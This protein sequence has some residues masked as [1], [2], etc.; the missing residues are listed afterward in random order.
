MFQDLRGWAQ[1]LA[2]TGPQLASVPLLVVEHAAEPQAI[3]GVPAQ[4]VLG[5]EQQCRTAENHAPLALFDEV[6]V[7]QECHIVE[8]WNLGV[9]GDTSSTDELPIQILN[10]L[11]PGQKIA[12][13]IGP[14]GTPVTL[15]SSSTPTRR[16]PPS[17]FEDATMASPISRAISLAS[18]G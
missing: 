13:L 1:E 5:E 3:V 8:L 16:S 11:A 14:V 18:R 15:P 4:R 10:L 12:D 7:A 17:E 6:P 9:E 2:L